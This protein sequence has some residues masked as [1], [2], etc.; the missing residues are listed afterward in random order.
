MKIFRKTGLFVWVGVGIGL[1]LISLMSRPAAA[2]PP[3]TEFVA[4]NPMDNGFKL[5]I[6]QKGHSTM[7]FK[8]KGADGKYLVFSQSTSMIVIDDRRVPILPKVPGVKL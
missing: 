5:V 4:V 2:T 7:L 3:A 6:D 1:G 8:I